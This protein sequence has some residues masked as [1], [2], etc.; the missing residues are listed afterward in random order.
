MKYLVVFPVCMPYTH[1]RNSTHNWGHSTPDNSECSVYSYWG[2]VVVP[3]L[4]LISLVPLNIL[5]TKKDPEL[6]QNW[7]KAPPKLA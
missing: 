1:Q 3:V 6:P 7:P 2:S 4:R 5:W